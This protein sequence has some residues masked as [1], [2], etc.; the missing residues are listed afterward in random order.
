MLLFGAY[1]VNAHAAYQAPADLGGDDI[2]LRCEENIKKASDLRIEVQQLKSAQQGNQALTMYNE[3]LIIL[4]ES[5]NEAGLLAEVHPHEKIRQDA[6]SCEQKAS[7]FLT[8]LSLDK[9]IYQAIA[10]TDGQGFDKEDQRMLEHTILDFKR[11]G[12]DQSDET[13]ARIKALKDELVLISQQFGENI[14]SDK[15]YIE[16]DHKSDLDGLP[17]DYIDSHRQ[18]SGK[19]LISTDYPDFTPFMEYAKND[20]AR[21]QLRMKYL[22]RGQNNGPVLKAMIEKRHELAQLLNYKSYA[23]Y[24]AQD[25][26]IKSSD[27]IHSFIER[28]SSI[29]RPGADREYEELLNYKRRTNTETTKIEGHENSFLQEAYKKERFGFASQDVRPYFSYYQVRDGL[30]KVTGEL[31]GIRYEPV[32]DAKVWHESVDTYD[33]FDESGK[34]GRIYLDMF[35]REGKFSHAAQFPIR[36]GLSDRQYPE[37]ALVCNFPNPNEGDGN[38]L[39]EHSQV[40]TFF[41]EFGHLLH[42]VFAGRQKWIAFSGVA[43]EWDFVEAP[44]QLLEEWAWSPEVLATFARHYQ[45]KEPIP[46]E[47][48]QKMR[49][50]E[51]FGKALS[52]RQQMFYAALSVNYYDLDPQTFDTQALLKEMQEKYSYI[53]YEEGTHF[54]YSFGHLDDYSAIYYTYMWSLS[55][56]KD[57]LTP[58]TKDGLMDKNIATRYRRFVLE[59]GGSKDASELV[60]QFL[61]RPFQFDAFEKWLSS[62]N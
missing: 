27:A 57:M 52:A 17:Q 62:R 6:E 50:A 34:L 59:P 18:A 51:E 61:G 56:A 60:E 14:R 40:Q 7:A 54:N 3:I 10:K 26:M 44:S 8:D 32:T 21:R 29:A 45:T 22:N 58:F 49:A 15:F 35:P 43:T 30:L 53:P 31:F 5:L 38:A 39:M 47:L 9:E 28:I 25:K 36:S 20:D 4:N 2:L 1:V 13:R 24:V 42:H 16:L 41:H 37:G 55:L 19:Y 46:A 11:S 48:V 23:D 12:V 33:V